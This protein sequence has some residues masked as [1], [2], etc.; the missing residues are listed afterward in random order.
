MKQSVGYFRATQ[1]S[2]LYASGAAMILLA[3]TLPARATE[4]FEQARGFYS[5]GSL[6]NPSQLPTDGPGFV[7]LFEKRGR[8]WGTED[9][10]GFIVEAASR[11]SLAYPEGERLQIGDIAA[12]KGGHISGHDSHQN[13]LDADIV[14]YRR[15]HV[16]QP[17]D[18]EAKGF[19]ES[20]VRGNRVTPNFDVDRNWEIIKLL[21]SS[22][23]VSRIFMDGAIKRTLC[24]HAR[25]L[26]EET[27]FIQTLRILRPLEGHT[28]HM[29]LRITCP[30]GS[31]RCQTQEP[32]PT[33]SGC[34][35]V[36]Y[37]IY[38]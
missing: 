20:F 12:Q 11:M 10:V 38:P 36:A 29:H 13:G 22:D 8:Y 23:R 25:A 33:G 16:E 18:T 7:H 14:F 21:V 6:V 5:S 15:N 34:Q 30:E 24:L 9:L 1:L 19:I 31:P 37:M 2:K 3:Q 28:D 4:T 17:V 27:T 35:A 32:P 26:G